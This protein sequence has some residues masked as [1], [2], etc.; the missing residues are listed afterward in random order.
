M[1]TRI[2]GTLAVALLTVTAL[3]AFI[4]PAGAITHASQNDAYE[5][6]LPA[7]DL[8]S[9]E[10]YD[11]DIGI[12]ETRHAMEARYGGKW[13][14]YSWN[15]MSNTP[16]HL[17]GSA[18][19]MNSG[20]RSA[21][22]VE[23]LARQVISENVDVL[24]ADNANLRLHATPHALGK[25]VAHFQQTH[26]GIDVWEAKVRVA[27]SDSGKLLLMGSDYYS[28]IDLNTT[29]SL[30]AG[31]AIAIATGDLPYNP[32]TDRVEE[33]PELLVLP[34]AVGETQVEHRLVW[35]LK[36]RTDSPLGAWMTHVD[37]HSGEI[38]W[39][40]NDI[41]FAFEGDTENDS[42]IYGICD[43][44]TTT[45]APYLDINVSGAGSTTS[46]VDGNW[47]IAGG[48]GTATVTAGL[49]GPWVNVA[50][51]NGA[52]A[53]FSG[54]ATS[55]VPFTVDFDAGNARQ[56]ERSTFDAVND[57]HD[58]FDLFDAS[59]GYSNVGINAYVNRTDGYCPGNA[60]WDGTI[61][62]CAAGGSYNNT[63]ELQQV[64]H[65]EFG[66][67]VQAH[68]IGSQGNEGLGEGNSDILGNLITQ[69]PII[70]RGFYTGNCVSGIRNSLNTLQYPDDLGSIHH[71]GQIIAGFNWD[72]MVQLQDMYGGGANWDGLGTIMSAE[73]WHF[74]RIL[75]HPT[76]QPDQVF[77]TFFA[78]DDN[79]NMDDGTEHYEI[80]CEAATNHGFDCPEILVGVFVSHVNL[81]YTPDTAQGY[82]VLGQAISLGGGDVLSGSVSVYYRVNG[83]VFNQTAMSATANP[84]E[85]MGMIPAQPFNSVVEYYLEASNDLGS[86][87]TSP[88][89]APADLHYFQVDDEF[90]DEM[91]I[92]TAWSVGSGSD[93]TASTGTW[94]RADPQGTD[95]SGVV[96]PEDDHT[97]AGTDCW[98]TGASAGSS[99]GSNDV[100]NGI[101]TLYSPFFD[102]EGA[103]DVSVSYWRY[104]TNNMGNDPG[105]RFWQV[106]VSND[107]GG[108]W[109]NVEY[110]QASSN[111]W[112]NITFNLEDYFATPGMVQMRF[113]ASDSPNGA[114]VE[115][116]VD[117]FILMGSFDL[118]GV[119]DDDGMSVQFVTNL[120]QN[121]P[122]PFNPKTEIR[123][124]LEQAGNASLKVYDASGR[125]VKSLIEG[126][127]TAGEQI[128]SW[129]GMDESGSS[130]ASGMYFY[131]LQTE[132]RVIS[133]RMLLLK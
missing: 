7:L 24:K 128:V 21:D 124:S 43:G 17:Y 55:G 68:I 15:P 111:M 76:Y 2:L 47:Y 75:M 41:H 49:N 8:H 80:F 13:S 74:G 103:S 119:G 20:L 60:W 14:V 105:T 42:Q 122:N 69:D 71:S 92:D 121:S 52:E 81:P 109:T 1:R 116:L 9:Q 11:R 29:P 110:T 16:R 120:K 6:S 127:L 130:V 66:H 114:L 18:V 101:T 115:A 26:N 32:A 33:R 118:T 77:A 100:D 65:H 106:Q 59:F 31:T 30:P 57:I 91:E 50:N 78:D 19:Q 56:D 126:P 3:A 113:I 5:I 125:L 117:D 89:N 37:A 123:F 96:Q 44:V 38:L 86:S 12:L 98:V 107:G 70:G 36:V 94:E 58:F 34:I 104:Y 112:E 53:A 90:V 88:G 72:A 99:A 51:Y 131:R 108:N 45:N 132:D 27:F 67:G 10:S 87:G 28:N 61:N 84:D 97:A 95:Y 54:M 129:N 46:D 4:S 79:D 22:A 63:G 35:R 102:L 62:F 40:Y 85:Y 93:N 73:R 64:V 82:E 83:G 133:K 48:G 25:W 39:R 23:S